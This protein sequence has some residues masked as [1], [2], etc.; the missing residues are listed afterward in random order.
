MTERKNTRI[1]KKAF[2]FAVLFLIATAGTFA[3]KTGTLELRGTVPEILEI[4]IN[5][6]G[7]QSLDLSQNVSGLNVGNVVERSN[8]KTGYTVTVESANGGNFQS[9]DTA[10]TD[11]LDYI[12]SYDGSSV[13]LTNGA[14]EVSN[15]DGKTAS[16][17]A[18]NALNISYNGADSFLYE[19]TYS[20][21]LTFTI[22]AK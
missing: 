12:L 6:N 3:A 22:A 8:K 4:T 13:T 2:I 20:D 16:D 19:D 21:T 11:A 9:S 10:N 1:Y 5:S 18:S 17:G 14:V 15:V 7:A